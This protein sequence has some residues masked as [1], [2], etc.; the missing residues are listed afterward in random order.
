ML[1]QPSK[2]INPKDKKKT[3]ESAIKEKNEEEEEKDNSS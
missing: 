1:I 2:K 3:I